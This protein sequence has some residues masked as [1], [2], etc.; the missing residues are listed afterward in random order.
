MFTITNKSR[1]IAALGA[2]RWARRSVK[3]GAMDKPRGTRLTFANVMATGAMFVA[4]G[5]GGYAAMTRMPDANGVFHGCVSKRTGV[6]RVVAGAH[7]CTGG[8]D[9]A[10]AWNQ[11]GQAGGKGGQ[12]APGPKGDPAPAAPTY[13]A[14]TGMILANNTFSIDPTTV[15]QRVTGSCPAGQA[16]TAIAQN[17]LVTCAATGFT[18][19]V[20]RVASGT[21]DG[22]NPIIA[23]CDAGEVATGGGVYNYSSNAVSGSYAYGLSGPTGW[24]TYGTANG[25]TVQ[26]RVLCA[27]H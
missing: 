16:I 15:Q 2:R 9:F 14:G 5:G 24:Q 26:S 18:K 3:G 6:L 20:E 21:Y 1:A 17:G 8:R 11:R 7:S 23:N 19:I 10:I 4:L 27:T 13:S 25:Q 12:G 22:S